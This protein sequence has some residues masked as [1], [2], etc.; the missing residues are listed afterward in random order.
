MKTISRKAH[1]STH[2]EPPNVGCYNEGEAATIVQSAVES[3]GS[4]KGMD[5]PN[6]IAPEQV[7]GESANHRA[8]LFAFAYGFRSREIRRCWARDC[9][10]NSAAHRVVCICS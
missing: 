2:S 3:T 6:Y 9:A 5:T 7:R 4:G 8:D 10:S 1:A